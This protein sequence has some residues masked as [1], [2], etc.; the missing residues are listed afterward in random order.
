MQK[1][2][3]K[4]ILSLVLSASILICAFNISRYESPEPQK[5]VLEAPI[6]RNIRVLLAWFKTIDWS[7]SGYH[8]RF[9]PD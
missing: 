2:F 7:K 6:V 9:G 5:Q 4:F 8:W 3:I 1:L